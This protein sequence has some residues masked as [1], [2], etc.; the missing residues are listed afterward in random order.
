MVEWPAL[1]PMAQ[2]S[3]YYILQM[4]SIFGRDQSFKEVCGI[5]FETN[6]IL[7]T[8]LNDIVKMLIKSENVGSHVI[9][10][11]TILLEARI[12]LARLT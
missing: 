9:S 3:I 5:C 10:N 8:Q 1:K 6:K 11:L 2:D 12:W 7:T 4:Q